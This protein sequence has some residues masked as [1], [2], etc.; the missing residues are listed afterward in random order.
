MRGI[1]KKAAI[2]LLAAVVLAGCG[3][4]APNSGNGLDVEIGDGIKLPEDLEYTDTETGDI[5]KESPSDTD[6]SDENSRKIILTYKYEI[7]TKD[8]DQSVQAIEKAVDEVGGYYEESH[9][10]GNTENG[11]DASYVLRIPTDKLDLFIDGVGTFGNI[12][13]QSKNGQDVT[14]QYYDIE[15]R[16]TSLKIQ[17]ERILELLKKA[18][19]LDDILKLESELTKVRNNIEKLTTN[20]KKYDSLIDYTTVTITVDQVVNYTDSSGNFADTIIKTFG[21]SFS[22][23]LEIL[24]MI[25]ISLIWLL[26]YIIVI[27]LIVTLAVILDRKSKKKHAAKRNNRMT[28]QPVQPA[29]LSP[30]YMQSAQNPQPMP[31]TQPL[32]SVQ[33]AQPTQTAQAATSATH[34]PTVQTEQPDDTKK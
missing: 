12:V 18:N 23:A 16:L 31:Y 21:E 25:I 6:S 5:Q 27:G 34:V 14:S 3:K 8:L 32:Q 4:G 13:S 28:A 26:P 22:F 24:K 29:T 15:S 20:L 30:S 17:Q 9:I 1:I 33:T 11:G 19:S 7:E 2:V 10:D